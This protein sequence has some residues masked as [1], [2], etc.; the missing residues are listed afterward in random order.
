MPLLIVLYKDYEILF[1]Y[2]YTL[3]KNLEMIMNYCNSV[4][5]D[6]SYNVVIFSYEYRAIRKRIR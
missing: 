6:I 4:I 2:D 5:G 1:L 3:Y